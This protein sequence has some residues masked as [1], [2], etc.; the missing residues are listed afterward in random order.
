MPPKI[1]EPEVRITRYEVSCLQPGDHTNADLFTLT[2]E[3]RGN[4]SVRERMARFLAELEPMFADRVLRA[5][6]PACPGCG[7]VTD[8]DP[9]RNECG[10][11]LGCNDDV[12]PPGVNALIK[13]AATP[14]TPT[15]EQP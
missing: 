10:C 8:D 13:A 7:C 11:D 14:N 9:D 3:W 2:V 15:G 1:P 12:Y 6:L 4:D 5:V